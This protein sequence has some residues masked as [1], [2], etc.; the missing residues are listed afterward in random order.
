MKIA[1]LMS[2]VLA[3]GVITLTW[4]HPTKTATGDPLPA[5]TVI[6]Y[7]VRDLTGGDV[8]VY[9]GTNTVATV[10]THAGKLNAWVVQ[11][12]F[13]GVV[14]KHSTPF[15]KASPTPANPTALGEE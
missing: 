7:R 10:P 15:L 1:V 8:V 4:R 9:E 6:E 14:S 12:V 3:A 2:H 13:D 11:A 5:G